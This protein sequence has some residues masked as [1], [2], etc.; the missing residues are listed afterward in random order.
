MPRKV[1][2]SSLLEFGGWTPVYLSN[3]LANGSVVQTF[4]EGRDI[5]LWRSY[6]GAINAWSNRCPHRGMRLSFG[7]VR[8]ESLACIYHGWHYG[9]DGGCTYIPAHPDLEPPKSICVEKFRCAE[10]AGIIWVSI[11]SDAEDVNCLA[12]MKPIR[13]LV[14]DVEDSVVYDQL[15]MGNIFLDRDSLDLR[16]AVQKIDESTCQIHVVSECDF[17]ATDLKKVSRQLEAWRHDIET[18]T[19]QRV[20]AI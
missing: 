13:S 12:A 17:T 9:S 8:G 4:V 6:S 5:A 7:F 19:D 3:H 14:V 20:A 16:F 1:K 18:K 2:N 11:D 10:T 15:K